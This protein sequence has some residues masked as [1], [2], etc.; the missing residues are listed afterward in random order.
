MEIRSIQTPF[1]VINHE[2]RNALFERYIQGT[3]EAYAN[4]PSNEWFVEAVKHRILHSSFIV[5]AWVNEVYLAGYIGVDNMRIPGVGLIAYVGI[6]TVFLEHKKHGIMQYLLGS[7]QGFDGIMVRTQ[8]PAILFSM[9]QVFGDVMPI[10]EKPTLAARHCAKQLADLSG[11][12]YDEER[13][14]SLGIYAGRRLTGVECSSGRVWADEAIRQ[15]LNADKGDAII[16]VSLKK[17]EKPQ[18]S[19]F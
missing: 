9:Y 19:G 8:N 7:L 15:N 2:D 5:E 14:V 13:M 17:K 6:A 12:R 18:Y 4:E 3:L 10:T 16:L 1:T 11:G